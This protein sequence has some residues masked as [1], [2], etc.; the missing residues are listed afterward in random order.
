[1]HQ[2]VILLNNIIHFAENPW[3]LDGFNTSDLQL[4]YP[5]LYQDDQQVPRDRPCNI[6]GNVQGGKYYSAQGALVG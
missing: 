4:P 3:S 1:M 2:W 6:T 5:N